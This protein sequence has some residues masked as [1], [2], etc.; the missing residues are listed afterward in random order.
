MQNRAPIK[1][2]CLALKTPALLYGE[3]LAYTCGEKKKKKE[4]QPSDL[5]TLP[6]IQLES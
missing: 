4:S 2:V 5:D 6:G 3:K 1:T